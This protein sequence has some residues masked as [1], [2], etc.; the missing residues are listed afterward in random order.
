MRVFVQDP[1]FARYPKVLIFYQRVNLT[2]FLCIFYL[3]GQVTRFFEFHLFRIKIGLK[4][5]TAAP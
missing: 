2:L 4:S 5:N 1:H 3:M